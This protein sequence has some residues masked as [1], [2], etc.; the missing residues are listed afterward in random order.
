MLFQDKNLLFEAAKYGN[1][2]IGKLL[3][4]SGIDVNEQ[5]LID[6]N[7][8]LHVATS[9]S[10]FEFAKMLIFNDAN[11]NLVNMQVYYLTVRRNE[12]PIWAA[13]RNSHFRMVK[14]LFR[15]GASLNVPNVQG[16]T[17]ETSVSDPFNV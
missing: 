16:E 6:Q 4:D 15:S 1:P 2:V 17:L 14:L 13:A 5:S 3:I 11:V 10:N 7:T 9:R 12:S 8:A